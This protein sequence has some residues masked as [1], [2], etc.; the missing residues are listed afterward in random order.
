MLY[1]A[2]LTIAKFIKNSIFIKAWATAEVIKDEMHLMQFKEEEIWNDIA[3][4]IDQK[5]LKS[6]MLSNKYN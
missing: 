1:N 6:N 2:D 5:D 4:E 3:Y